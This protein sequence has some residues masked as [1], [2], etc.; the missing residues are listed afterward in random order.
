MAY[1]VKSVD[2]QATNAALATLAASGD[3][4][5][6]GQLWEINRGLLH[7]LFWRWFSSNKKLADAHGMTAEDFEQEGFFAVEYAAKT[8]CPEAGSFSTWLGQAAQRQINQAMTGDHRRTVI[9]SDGKRRTVSANPLN[10]CT[11]LD[12]PIDDE[13][14]EI[15]LGELQPDSAAANAMQAAEDVVYQEQLHAALEEA[16]GKLSELE[17]TVIQ[18]K[19][20]SGKTVR[21]IS[22][23]QGTTPGQINA[24][25]ASAITKLRRN[26]RLMLWREETIQRHAWHGTGFSA[27]SA[28]GS[29]EERTVEF[30][31]SHGAYLYDIR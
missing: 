4:F 16:L 27:W 10:H 22:Q 18:E 28:S 2:Q 12:T 11:S 15:T 9:V 8:Y 19:Y 26:P 3:S 31:D 13:G 24:A 6:L 14:G 1:T 5:A 7:K 21:Q 25:N 30:M 17:R 20:Y 23:E 29:V